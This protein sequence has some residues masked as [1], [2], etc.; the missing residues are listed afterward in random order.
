VAYSL[1][2]DGQIILHRDPAQTAPPG[3]AEELL[4]SVREKRTRP[5]RDDKV[6]AD[7]NGL[8]IAALAR[9]GG[10]FEEPAFCGAAAKAADFIL[11]RMR[12]R[13]GRLFHRSRESEAA[14]GAF[15]DDYAFLAWGLLE[16]Y[17][18][19]FEVRHLERAVEC[20]E[21]LAAHYWD[22]ESGG[23]FRTADDA[24]GGPVD[25]AKPLQDGVIPS[26][27]SV[28]LLVF[29]KLAEITGSSEWRSRAESIVRQYPSEAGTNA[30]AFGFFLSALDFFLG[31]AIQ[32]VVA[33]DPG[34]QD[35][36]AMVRA[37]RQRYLPNATLVLRPT[38]GSG[39]AVT[40]IAPSTEPQGKLEGKATAYVCTGWSCTLPTNS[41]ETMISRLESLAA[42][43]ASA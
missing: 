2:G 37:L 33:G 5:S 40:R 10:T 27:N 24:A 42:G 16:L 14:I 13:N 22:R 19:T 31:P 11:G 25:R 4:L 28:G 21:A 39:E 29:T 15:A 41:V 3:R 32:V 35:T 38:D 9:A 17:E 18:A 23:L 26:A 8:M 6:L 36:Q 1:D 30:M 43:A 7:W 20:A 34:A 12:G